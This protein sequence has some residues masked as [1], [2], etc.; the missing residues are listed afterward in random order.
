MVDTVWGEAC[1]HLRAALSDKNY[2]TWILPLRATRWENGALTLEVPSG[3]F[4]DWLRT[5]HLAAIA[6]AVTRAAG[7][8]AEIQL[9]VNRALDAP[10]PA[11]A[12]MPRPPIPA[13]RGPRGAGPPPRYTFD[14]FVVGESNRMAHDAMRAVVAHPGTRFNPLFLYGGSG[15]GKTHLLSAASHGLMVKDPAGVAH[16]SAEAFV[17]EMIAALRRDQME[18]FRERF[19]GIRTL[20][21]DDVQFLAGKVRSQEEFVHTFNTLHDGRRQII[22][23]SDRPPHEMPGIEDALRGRFACGLMVDVR[24]PDP[25]LRVAIVDTKSGALGL[26]LP[27][28]VRRY[29][30]DHWCANVRELEG[31]LARVD[32]LAALSGRPLTLTAIREALPLRAGAGTPTVEHIVE[33]VCR[34]FDVSPSDLASAR[35]TARVA[36][37]RQVAM[38]LCRQHTDEPLSAIGR[39]LGGRDHSTVLHALGAI[40]RRLQDDGGLRQAVAA[41]EKRLRA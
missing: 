8:A 6:E 19:R 29:L 13:P 41:L 16:L 11:A 23:A 40:E 1:T 9:V 17:N 15:L 2:E 31:A 18:R 28:D 33:E 32:A 21:V 36:V 25:A 37:P 3:F 27:A 20:V 14:T 38:Y 34:H 26:A 7:R 4:R 30:A 5:R 22:L 10:A 24:P 35:R 39:E 12:R